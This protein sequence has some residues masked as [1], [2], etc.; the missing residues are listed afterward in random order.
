MSINIV[1]DFEKVSFEQF[2]K[3]WLKQCPVPKS[4]WTDE[5]LHE[6]YDNINLVRDF[7]TLLG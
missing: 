4:Q 2:K 6:I 1:A 7:W 3:D 5:E